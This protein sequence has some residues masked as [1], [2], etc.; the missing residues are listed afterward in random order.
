MRLRSKPDSPAPL[1]FL[2]AEFYRRDAVSIA[3]DLLGRILVHETP[4]GRAAGRIV[5]TEA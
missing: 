4:Q 3:R 1:L 5:E 2:R